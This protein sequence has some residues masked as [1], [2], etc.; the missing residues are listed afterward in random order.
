MHSASLRATL[1][2]SRSRS[3]RSSSC[4]ATSTAVA[5]SKRSSAAMTSVFAS[6]SCSSILFQVPSTRDMERSPVDCDEGA[7]A[8]SDPSEAPPGSTRSIR[9]DFDAGPIVGHHRVLLRALS[10]FPD[11]LDESSDTSEYLDLSYSFQPPLTEEERM[12]DFLWKVWMLEVGDDV[13]TDYDSS[14]GGLGDTGGDREIHP[15]PPAGAKTLTL[16]IGTPSHSP[17]GKLL[18]SRPVKQLTVDLRTGQVVAN[19]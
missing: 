4:R 18:G 12:S 15:A 7:T 16:S 11:L 6:P 5:T 2:L 9:I 14:T 10:W 19:E 3:I 13:G 17:G 8:M 1:V